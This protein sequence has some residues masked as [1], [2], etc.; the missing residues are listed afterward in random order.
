MAGLEL[1]KLRGVEQRFVHADF[2]LL[3][4][5]E[6]GNLEL[7]NRLWKLAIVQHRRAIALD[8]QLHDPS[9]LAHFR[10]FRQRWQECVGA[11][12]TGGRPGK[13]QIPRQQRV[14][15]GHVLGRPC[16]K[17]AL[18]NPAG[19]GLNRHSGLLP[20]FS[21]PRAVTEARSALPPLYHR[22][23][24]MREVTSEV[25]SA[26]RGDIASEIEKWGKVVKTARIKVD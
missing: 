7:T 24:G 6:R 22:K 10:E 15:R 12:V 18:D 3:D 21:G 8:H 25:R 13:F 4:A 17:I 11:L 14:R 20:R 5:K 2:P 26:P 9:P 16:C 23:R 1:A 19:L